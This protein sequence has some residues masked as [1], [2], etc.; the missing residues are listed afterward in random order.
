[1]LT[2]GLKREG[3]KECSGS[4]VRTR[5]MCRVENEGGRPGMPLLQVRNTTAYSLSNRPKAQAGPCQLKATEG[6]DHAARVRN[7]SRAALLRIRNN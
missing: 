3:G 7:I 5:V 4:T 2:S 6:T 1:M